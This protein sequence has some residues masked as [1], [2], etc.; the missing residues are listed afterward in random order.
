MFDSSLQINSLKFDF[1]V[2]EVTKGK[3][4][5]LLS[6]PQD[7]MANV[8]EYLLHHLAFSFEDIQGLHTVEAE[9]EAASLLHG[10]MLP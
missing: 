1:E 5:I 2:T 3:V 8:K 4:N 10:L 6:K 9:M 7:R